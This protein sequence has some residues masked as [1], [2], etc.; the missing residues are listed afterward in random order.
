MYSPGSNFDFQSLNLALNQELIELFVPFPLIP[1]CIQKEQQGKRADPP[2]S[3]CRDLFHYLLAK[4]SPEEWS[5]IGLTEDDR[6]LTQHMANQEVG[7][8]VSSR[9]LDSGQQSSETRRYSGLTLPIQV[10]LTNILGVDRAAK[11]CECS[12]AIL[13]AL[14][15][16]AAD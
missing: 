10:A 12:G 16:P 8:A 15:N 6:T 5:A 7:H 1:F 4:F 11:Q 9:K 14:Q 13:S 2:L 3:S